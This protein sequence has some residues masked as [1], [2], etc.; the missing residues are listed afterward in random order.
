MSTD[1]LSKPLAVR[2]IE[3]DDR[4]R[5]NP[6]ALLAGVATLGLV[7]GLTYIVVKGD[8]LGGEPYVV[9]QIDRTVSTGSVV[10]PVPATP[11]KNKTANP[12]RET[13][14]ESEDASGVRVI[15]GR[16]GSG[17]VPVAVIIKV[18]DQGNA[19]GLA[20][21][22]RRL[23]ERGR[24]GMLP[25]IDPVAGAPR[26]VYARPFDTARAAGKPLIAIVVT[27]LG[28]GAIATTEAINKLPGEVTLAFAPYGK[29]LEKETVRARDNG[30]EILLQ[31][32]MEPYGYPQNDTGPHTLLA[33]GAEAQNI[34]RLHW[35]MSRFQGYIG[36]TNFMGAK[37]T[38]IRPALKPVLDETARRGL[39]F[40]DDGASPRSLVGEVA[41]TSRLPTARGDVVLDGL[42][43]PAD[44]EAALTRAE[45]QARTNGT[46][47]VFGPALPMTVERLS[48]WARTLEAKGLMLAPVSALVSK[49][50]G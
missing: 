24:H 13:A 31:A 10:L 7:G 40:I 38:G 11:D 9:T 27:G 17:A 33:E 36:V 50:R 20:S 22:D 49:A 35:L 42:D 44:F 46:A 4:R 45:T 19:A 26:D 5:F 15:R 14:Q 18:P 34:D 6:L 2:P 21:L 16:G 39:M 30:H 32:P 3:A 8:P 37:F 28:I 43:K 47:I 23:S 12:D 41:A 1:D 25:K 48:R 29:D